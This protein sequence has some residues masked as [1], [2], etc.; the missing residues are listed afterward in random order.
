MN[1]PKVSVITANYNCE[2]FLGQTI[3]SV[4]NQKFKDWEYIIADDGSTDNS[5]AIIEQKFKG[6]QNVKLLKL[7]S[8]SGPAYARNHALKKAQG[9][10]ISF[11]DSDDLWEP[12]FLEKMIAFMEEK[13]ITFA[14]SSYC[15]IT[16]DGQ[17]LDQY[18]VPDKVNYHDILK[19]CPICPLTTIYDTSI[20]G[21][22]LMPDI[23]KREDYGLFIAL[24]KKTKFAYALQKPLAHYRVREGSVSS[25]KIFIAKKQWDVYRR[26]EKLSFLKSVY[27]F[28]HYIFFSFL[29][30]KGIFFFKLNM[31]QKK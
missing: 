29:K 24:L 21:K 17:K 16:E 30:Y 4:L 11:I 1:S 15:R 7:K 9:R 18:T 25:N 27:Y 28:T 3:D 13:Q 10:Y 31:A 22:V 26:Y 5:I 19:S 12:E 23:P 20:L 8:N 14:Y 6:L 2:N